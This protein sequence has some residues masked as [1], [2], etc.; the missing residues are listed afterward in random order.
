MLPIVAINLDCATSQVEA[1][2]YGDLFAMLGDLFATRCQ[3]EGT[4]E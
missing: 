3:F 2:M 4:M 1:D